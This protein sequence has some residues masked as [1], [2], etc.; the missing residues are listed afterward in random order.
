MPPRKFSET[1]IKVGTLNQDHPLSDAQLKDG[2]RV[3][4]Q[5]R[6]RGAPV[7]FGL[8]LNYETGSILWT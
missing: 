7:F 1:H 5:E 3:Q 6:S 2:T 4:K 8:A